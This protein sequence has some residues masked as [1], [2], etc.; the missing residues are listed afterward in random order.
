MNVDLMVEF[1]TAPADSTDTDFEGFLDQVLEELDK[2]GR[3]DIDVSASLAKRVVTFTVFG[4]D[5]ADP[6]TDDFLAA[7]RTALHAANCETPGWE[8][9]AEIHADH[10]KLVEA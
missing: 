5:D 10:V 9:I 8:S 1:V 7:V 3:D 2:I 4:T 6:S